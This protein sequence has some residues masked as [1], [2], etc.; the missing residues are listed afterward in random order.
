MTPP[1]RG[2]M[3]KIWWDVPSQP[4]GEPWAAREYMVFGKAGVEGE[5]VSVKEKEYEKD[6]DAHPFGM[7][8]EDDLKFWSVPDYQRSGFGM[9]R[10]GASKDSKKYVKTK[11]AKMPHQ[12]RIKF[13]FPDSDF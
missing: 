7:G 4:L 1:V 8:Y 12:K 5:P 3:R 6:L 11:G 13:K 2:S 10:R 9:G